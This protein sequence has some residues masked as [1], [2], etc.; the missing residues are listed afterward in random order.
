MSINFPTSIDSLT[1]PLGTDQVAVVDHALQHSNANDAIEA[2]EAKVGANSSAVTTSHDYKLQGVTGSDK[3][4]SV[5][6]TETLTNK[7]LT[8]PKLANGGYIADANGNE[9]IEG[10]TTASATNHI[11]TTNAATGNDPVIEA[12]GS[13][14]DISLKIKGKG[15]GKVKIG[16]ADLQFPNVDGSG[17]QVMVT[18]GSGVLSWATPSSGVGVATT[19]IPIASTGVTT[20]SGIGRSSNT[21]MDFGMIEINQNITVNKLTIF[22]TTHTANGTLKIGFYSDDGQTKYLEVTTAT[23]TASGLYTTTLGSPTLLSAGR[24]IIAHVPTGTGNF[25]VYMQYGVTGIYSNF[26]TISGEQYY[27][28]YKT[29]TAGTLPTTFDPTASVTAEQFSTILVRLDN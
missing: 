6:G 26:N 20:V 23:I 14:T 29:V 10:T 24:Y 7:T 11:G 15:T 13:D 3:A 12:K 8:A 5:T 4:S 1:N 16:S 19:L 18:N 9:L 25:D 21:R 2:I 28:G 17:S 22:V 27:A